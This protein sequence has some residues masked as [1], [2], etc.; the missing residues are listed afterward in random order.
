VI[1]LYT[2]VKISEDDKKKLEKF[3]ALLTIE[4]DGKASQQNILSAIID[5]AYNRREELLRKLSGIKLP[6]SDD[7]FKKLLSLVDDWGVETR[8]EEIDRYLYGLPKAEKR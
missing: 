6:L 2:S 4:G 7:E 8:A 1:P 5:Y 3:Q